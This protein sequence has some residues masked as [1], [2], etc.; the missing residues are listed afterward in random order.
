MIR[1]SVVHRYETDA[2]ACAINFKKVNVFFRICLGDLSGAAKVL[3]WRKPGSEVS[4]PIDNDVY[5]L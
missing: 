1:V 3:P 2:E 4:G 5:D